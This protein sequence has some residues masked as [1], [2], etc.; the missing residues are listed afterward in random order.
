MRFYMSNKLCQLLGIEY[1]II[2]EPVHTLTNGKMIAAISEAGA[3][4]TLGINAGYTVNDANSGASSSSK[5]NIGN[6]KEYSILDTMTERNLMNE[7]IDS[8]LE[9]TFRPFAIEVASSEKFRK[10]IQPR[11]LLFN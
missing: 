11:K 5:E 9:N 10:K 1:P 7:Q 8:A 6:I 3:L 2:Q 4:G